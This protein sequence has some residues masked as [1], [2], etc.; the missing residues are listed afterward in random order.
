MKNSSGIKQQVV[1]AS[2]ITGAFDVNRNETLPSDDFELVKNWAD[3]VQKAG[4]QGIIFHNGFSEET[5]E[6]HQN[7]NLIFIKCEPSSSFNPNVF[8]YFLYLDFLLCYP[9]QLLTLL[10]Q[11]Q[12]KFPLTWQ[13]S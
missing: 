3:S 9:D 13:P 6:K 12:I 7:E 5:C 8:R 10:M 11:Q 2:L 4:L 1:M